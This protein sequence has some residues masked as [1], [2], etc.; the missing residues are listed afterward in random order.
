MKL[1]AVFNS[2][3]HSGEPVLEGDFSSAED[4]FDQFGVSKDI[5]K[6]IDIICANYETGDYSGSAAV[7]YYRRDTDKYYETY[8]SHC[9][10]YGLE[11]QWGE[12]EIVFVELENRLKLNNFFGMRER[13]AGYS[14]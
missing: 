9:S 1:E 7:F 13:L 4:V 3:R 10:C 8:G 6:G 14:E 12:E 2:I 5:R 11:D